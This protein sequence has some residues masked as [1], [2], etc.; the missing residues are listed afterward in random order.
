MFCFESCFA[1]KKIFVLDTNVLINKPSC[2]FDF[3]ENDIV[4]PDDVVEE[5]DKFKSEE[6][7]NRGFQAREA[8]RL[9]DT[10]IDTHDKNL[11][12]GISLG[13]GKGTIRVEHTPKRNSGVVNGFSIERSVDN[14]II[15]LCRELSRK[16]VKTPVVLLSTD[17]NIR[18]KANVEGVVAKKYCV[19]FTSSNA[20]NKENL[21][22]EN[23]VY[24]GRSKTF[25]LLTVFNNFIRCK[26]ISLDDLIGIDRNEPPYNDETFKTKNFRPNEFVEVFDVTHINKDFS[27]PRPI[28]GRFDSKSNMIESLL[29]LKRFLSNLKMKNDVEIVPKNVGQE[30]ALEALLAPPEKAPLVIIKGAAGTA[31]TFLTIAAGIDRFKKGLYKQI[32]IT[33]PNVGMD[34]DI[35]FLPGK[36]QDKVE[37]LIRPFKDNLNVIF[38]FPKYQKVTVHEYGK[39]KRPISS[40]EIPYGESF[41]YDGTIK[42]ESLAFLRGRSLIDT[43]LVVDEVQN[44]TISQAKDIATRAGVGTKIVLLGDPRQID[45]E[46]LNSQNNGLNYIFDLAKKSS[47]CWQVTL[48]DNEGTRSPLAT[49]IEQLVKEKELLEK[50]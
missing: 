30:F 41:F 38:P 8:I 17:T 48:N 16:V 21:Q 10:L 35:G 12:K 14:R 44:C 29:Y 1:M 7:S 46:D 31:K 2:I 13:E 27:L 32:I 19:D 23:K 6:E 9:L 11:Y 33:R 28:G 37:P 45:R 18:V 36:E 24:S 47:L 15:Y 40:Q 3:E 43:F 42:V 4:I 50:S 39:K 22:V 5:L 25:V 26:P 49:E 20:P 34:K